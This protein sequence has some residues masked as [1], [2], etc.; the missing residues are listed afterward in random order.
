MLRQER[1][2]LPAL[3]ERRQRERHHVQAVEEILPE[4]PLAHHRLEVAVRGR[5][6]AEVH[7]DRVVAAHP[8][9]GALLEDA[10]ELRLEVERHVAHLVQVKGAAVGQLQL[11][12]LPLL[13][14]GERA[15]LVAEELALEK[16]GGNGGAGDRD[17]GPPGAAAVVMDGPGHQLLAGAR[18]APQEDGDVAGCHTADGLVDLLH[19]R[20][21]AHEGAELPHLLEPGLEVL[22]FLGQALHQKRPLGEQEQFVHVEGLGEVIVGAPLHRLDGGLHGAV[23]RH[24]D[25]LGV[26]PRLSDFPEEGEAVHARHPNVEEDQVE[27][28]AA[29]LLEGGLPVLHRDDAIAGLLQALFQDPA[30]A[31]FVVGDQDAAVRHEIP[32]PHS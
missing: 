1:D 10:E 2:V 17:E 28:L 3:A 25:H 8:L 5:E 30:Q 12:E 11:P 4:A 22:D 15:S 21:P 19:P 23:G 27:G 18:L 32:S 9:E 13:G 24:D 26:G 7:A 14:V 16:V 29:G 20:V 31:V 6:H